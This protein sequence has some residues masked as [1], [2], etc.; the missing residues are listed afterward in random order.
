[1]FFCFSDVSVFWIMD[2]FLF[3]DEIV[4]SQLIFDHPQQV[5]S[6]WLLKQKTAPDILQGRGG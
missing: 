4:G 3:F 1:M 6:W 5:L 2:M